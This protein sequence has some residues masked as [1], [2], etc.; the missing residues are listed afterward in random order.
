MIN[1]FHYQ[2]K[3]SGI[4]ATPNEIKSFSE[5]ILILQNFNHPHVMSLIGVCLGANKSR[6]GPSIVLPFMSKGSLLDFLRKEANS[7]RPSINDAVQVLICVCVCLRACVCVCACVRVLCG[8][9]I[10]D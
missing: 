7:L 2:K 9:G 3:N 6:G 10:G 5:E 8:K 4:F 1:C